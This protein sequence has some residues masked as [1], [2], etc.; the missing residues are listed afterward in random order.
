MEDLPKQLAYLQNRLSIVQKNVNMV[1][2]RSNGK[3]YVL[4]YDVQKE[5]NRDLLNK[6][7]KRRILSSFGKWK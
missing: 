6:L 1:N 2:N 4:A 5:N 7:N 3:I